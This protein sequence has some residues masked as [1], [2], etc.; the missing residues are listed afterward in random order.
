MPPSP[1]VLSEDLVAEVLSF[2]PVKSLVCFRC[3]SKSWKT[4]ISEPTFVKL[5]LQKSQSQSL[6]TL[7]TMHKDHILH[8]IYE[9][10]DYSLVRYPINR[11]FENPSFTLV[12]DSHSHHLKM[13]G[14]PTFIVGSCNGLVLLVRKSKSIKDDHKSYC[15]R[16]WNPATWTSS[17]FFGHFRDIETFHFAFGCV[18]STGSF[19]VVAF[20]FRKETM[21]VRVLNLDHGDYLWRNIETFPVVPYRVFESH[22]HVYLS[23]TLNRLSIPNE[24]VEH[25]VIVSLDLETETYNQ[26]MVPCGFDQVT[27]SYNTPTIGVLGGCLCFSFL[28]KETDFVVWQM[29]KFGIEDSWTQLLK[30]SYHT[31]RIGYDFIISTLRSFFQLVPSLLSEDGDSM[32]LESNLESLTVQTILYNMRDNT[33]KQTQIIASRTTI[34]NRNGDR[35]YWSHANDY[36]ESLVPIP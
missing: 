21:E 5:H 9:V 27:H 29:K 30:I 2:L 24:T 31:L 35:V 33:A 19:K 32:I 17:D 36:V 18:N 7:I 23:G 4:L 25:S 10:E 1:A 13:E 22:E 34:D 6:C 12:H 15:L 26:Y 8:G 11:I 14:N 20:C 16:V 28:H 3:V